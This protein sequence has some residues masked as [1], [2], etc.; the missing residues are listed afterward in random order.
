MM[1]K[2]TLKRFGFNKPSSGLY[3]YKL[4]SFK[5]VLP[6]RGKADIVFSPLST[7]IT[8]KLRKYY[9]KV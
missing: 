2:S 7:W 6:G 5:Q 4:S 3:S 1:E 8:P 9:F